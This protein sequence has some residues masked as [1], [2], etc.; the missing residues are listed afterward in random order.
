MAVEA[1]PINGT[2][3]FDTILGNA[4]RSISR[5]IDMFVEFFG[6]KDNK[7]FDAAKYI[8]RFIP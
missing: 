6:R 5:F 2:V 1:M 7:P 8:G 3:M 4:K